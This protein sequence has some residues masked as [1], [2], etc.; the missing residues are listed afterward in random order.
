[1]IISNAKFHNKT[2]PIISALASLHLTVTGLPAGQSEIDLQNFNIHTTGTCMQ[3]KGM[4]K[5]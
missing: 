3:H 1:M 2:K 5:K 4:K